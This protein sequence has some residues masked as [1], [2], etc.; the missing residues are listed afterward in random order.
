MQGRDTYST[1]IPLHAVQVANLKE[2]KIQAKPHPNIMDP[3]PSSTGEEAT[4]IPATVRN[5]FASPEEKAVKPAVV[6]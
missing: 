4:G 6:Y 2:S 1:W 5:G 3:G